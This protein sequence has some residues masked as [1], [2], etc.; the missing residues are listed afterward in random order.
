VHANHLYSVA[1]LTDS[2]GAVTERYRYDAYGKQTITSA[3]GAMLARSSVNWNRGYT[4]YIADQETSLLYARSRMYSSFLGRFASRDSERRHPILVFS[5]D[6]YRDGF[7]LYFAYFAI[8]HIDP[9][10]TLCCRGYFTICGKKFGPFYNIR[11]TCIGSETSAPIILCNSVA[12]NPESPGISYGPT[13]VGYQS[14]G[15]SF[16][17][18]GTPS[19]GFGFSGNYTF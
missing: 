5:Q 15:W 18:G 19:G 3:V 16:N 4:G 13:G 11:E 8:N 6:G 1:A 2:T 17:L 14:G 10:G 12:P 7:S 9:L